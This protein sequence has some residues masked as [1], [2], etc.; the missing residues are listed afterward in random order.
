M[1]NSIIN[2]YCIY[3][4]ITDYKVYEF[5]EVTHSFDFTKSQVYDMYY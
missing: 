3:S 2:W 4:N 1:Y 5:S